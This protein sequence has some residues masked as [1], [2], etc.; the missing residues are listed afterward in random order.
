MSTTDGE[1]ATTG[2][3][4]RPQPARPD[5]SVV[6]EL[7][8]TE[9]A[10]KELRVDAAPDLRV[11]RGPQLRPAPAPPAPKPPGP[12]PTGTG[13]RT[14][15]GVSVVMPVLDEERH[16]RDAVGHVL[17]QDYPG[18]VEV[19]LA[20]GPSTDGTDAIAAQIA[21]ADPRVHAVA[22]PTGSTPAGLNAALARSRYPVVARVD[23]HGL[24][25]PGYLCTAV[26]LMERTGA[27]NVGGVMAAQGQTAF[28]RAVARA[29]RSKL[30]V[31]NARFHVGGQEGPAETVYLG[32]FRR[33]TLHRLGGYDEG[34]ARAQ[35]WELNWRIRRDGGQ[36][37]FSPSLQ[38][39]Y[40]PRRTLA[41][42]AR[43]YFDYGRWRRGVMRRHPESVSLRYLAP[44]AAVLAVGGGLVLAAAGRRAGL[45][46]PVGYAAS[47]LAGTGWIG[48]DLDPGARRWLPLVVATMHGSWGVGFLV[49]DSSIGTRPGQRSA[50]RPAA[51]AAPAVPPAPPTPAAPAAPASPHPPTAPVR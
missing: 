5:V 46:A 15:P 28:E 16:L 18:E 7:R 4:Q 50:L 49:S 47:V 22:N 26:E 33:E 17:A 9:P 51:Q 41:A 40:R 21:A 29:M 13:R 48:R 14:W 27:A 19:I 12:T 31:G 6:E 38:V 23:A 36:V 45:L 39:V 8:V 11:D 35:D 24:L 32:V 1:G 42:L 20:L 10:A 25:A 34:L 2:A 3:P 37:W 44:P 30:G 43:Q